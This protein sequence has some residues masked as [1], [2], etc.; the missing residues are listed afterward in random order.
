MFEFS[1][2]S[3]AWSTGDLTEFEESEFL[4]RTIEAWRS[5]SNHSPPLLRHFCILFL[6]ENLAF[7]VL[8]E[9]VILSEELSVG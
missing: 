8:A 4:A 6:S 9:D 7:N 3:D 5:V 1:G 2:K